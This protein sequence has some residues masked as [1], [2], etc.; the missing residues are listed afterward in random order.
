[1]IYSAD[2]FVVPLDVD[3]GSFTRV[4]DL[5]YT[6]TFGDVYR[7]P[8]VDDRGR[9]GRFRMF[10]IS[11]AGSDEVVNG[12]LIP[13][14][15]RGVIEGTPLEEVL[16]LR[17]EMANM[18]WAVE[19]TMQGPSGLARPRARE[20]VAAAPISPGPVG[21]AQLDYRLQIGPPENWIPYLPRAAGYRAVEL[22]QG[23]MVRPD[24]TPCDPLGRLLA[25]PD[26]RRLKD[27]EVPREGVVVRRR[28]SLTR[29]ADGRYERWI[30][31]QT[32]VGRGEGASRL[33]FDAAQPRSGRRGG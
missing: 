2:W 29:H 4:S 6:T 17:D 23:R 27:A 8:P 22:V 24:G 7:V 3:V 31:R 18:V 20:H 21:T 1:M 19:R 25:R 10:G 28:P 14:S 26:I 9:T 16:L 32:G 33:S 11:V 15:A 13:P 12:L 5:T 30:T